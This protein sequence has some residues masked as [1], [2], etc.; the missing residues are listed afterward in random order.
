MMSRIE[1][2]FSWLN[3][4]NS[5]ISRSVRRQNTVSKA[6]Q[7][8]CITGRGNMNTLEWSKGVIFCE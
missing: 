2:M 3:Q 7:L 6:D 5:L 1:M 8:L 4:R